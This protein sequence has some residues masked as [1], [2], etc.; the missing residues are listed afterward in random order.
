MTIIKAAEPAEEISVTVES[1]FDMP[2]CDRCSVSRAVFIA[3]KGDRELDFCLHHSRPHIQRL[4]DEEWQVM[5][6]SYLLDTRL[7]TTVE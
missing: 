7:S 5:D 1:L 4:K 3:I 6:Y 2:F